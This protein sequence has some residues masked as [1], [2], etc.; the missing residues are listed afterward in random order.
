[1]FAAMEGLDPLTE[2]HTITD[3]KG[4]TMAH[5]M[6]INALRRKNQEQVGPGNEI[7]MSFLEMT[8]DELKKCAGAALGYK[9]FLRDGQSYVLWQKRLLEVGK[10]LRE[11]MGTNVTFEQIIAMVGPAPVSEGVGLFYSGEF[12]PDWKD[13]NYNPIERTKKRAELNA[14]H[15]RFGTHAPVYEGESGIVLEGAFKESDPVPA[16]AS[17]TATRS[18]AQNLA[19]L[20]YDPIP[21]EH[22]APAPVQVEQVQPEPAQVVQPEP[23]PEAAKP[24]NDLPLPV[25]PTF[26]RMIDEG[27][28]E[29][30][31][32]AARVAASIKIKLDNVDE[33]LRLGRIYRGWR[34]IGADPKQAATHTL[35]GELPQ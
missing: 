29:N 11:A 16:L 8:P 25:H 2:V 20:G 32:E 13:K 31:H 28:V 1:M 17:S 24:T 5:T 12:S 23:K 35:A 26:Q 27:I 21:V 19:D 9:C 14:R 30:A 3:S 10:A 6:A 34:D 33:A 18:Q 4:Q 22:D 7:T 15:H